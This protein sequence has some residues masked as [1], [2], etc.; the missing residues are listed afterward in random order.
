MYQKILILKLRKSKL[1]IKSYNLLIK[2]N[3]THKHVEYKY[4]NLFKKILIFMGPTA[5]NII[6]SL[7]RH[8]QALNELRVALD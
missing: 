5:K 2:K 8:P 6:S 4:E 1:L 7:L 3:I